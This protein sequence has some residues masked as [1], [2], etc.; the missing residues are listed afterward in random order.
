MNKRALTQ[1]QRVHF[2]A[3]LATTS[4]QRFEYGTL[5][6]ASFAIKAYEAVTGKTSPVQI[7]WRNEAEANAVLA[8]M[9]G[10]RAAFTTALGEP[11]PVAACVRGDILLADIDGVV[12]VGVHDGP[13]MLAVAGQGVRGLM[14]VPWELVVCGWGIV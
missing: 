13:R 2:N 4:A 6:C 12:A 5:D 8:G 3:V 11:I 9:G 1:D 7:T 14:R 10:L